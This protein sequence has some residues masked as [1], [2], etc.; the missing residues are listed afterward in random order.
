MING[1]LKNSVALKYTF[2]FDNF[3]TSYDFLNDLSKKGVKAIGIVRENHTQGASKVLMN[4]I[5]RKK[6]TEKHLI[7]VVI[8][9]YSCKWKDNAIVLIG[10]NFTSHIMVSHTK[11]RVK[12]DQDCSIT[13]PNLIKEYNIGMG[14]VDVL[15]RL[16]GSCL[17]TI[18]GK[19]WY[20]PLS[21]NALNVSVVAAWRIHCHV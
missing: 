21:I 19:K 13:Q 17:Q 7:S 5:A 4:T 2:Y 20:W 1:V 9:V 3:F 14:S 6:Q 18:R 15:D 10:T 16:V 12:K 11:Q 8:V